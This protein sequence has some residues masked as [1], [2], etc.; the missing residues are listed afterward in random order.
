MAKFLWESITIGQFHILNHPLIITIMDNTNIAGVIAFIIFIIMAIGGSY[1][2]WSGID[3]YDSMTTQSMASLKASAFPEQA[4]YQLKTWSSGGQDNA[5]VVYNPEYIQMQITFGSFTSISGMYRSTYAKLEIAETGIELPIEPLRS[6]VWN[7]TIYTYQ[8]NVYT[9][10]GFRANLTLNETN[11]HQ[12]IQLK[13]KMTVVYPQSHDDSHFL[14]VS[15]TFETTKNLFV[16]T[17]EEMEL[18]QQLDLKYQ[19]TEL[20]GEVR[21]FGLIG[22]FIL[23]LLIT[24]GI[25]MKLEK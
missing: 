2:I 6:D 3:Y 19:S 5:L 16:V 10:C 1:L 23:S 13:A 12:T 20:P 4:P 22:W 9:S 17:P 25:A 14:D 8:P 21:F 11:I 15:Q 7:D 24:A 18:K